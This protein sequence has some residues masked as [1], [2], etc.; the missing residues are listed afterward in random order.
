MT[1]E[2]RESSAAWLPAEAREVARELS[3]LSPAVPGA[4]ALD[5]L[6]GTV[7]AYV[8]LVQRRGD[9]I[10]VQL[11]EVRK[12]CGGCGAFTTKR[13]GRCSAAFCCATCFGPHQQGCKKRN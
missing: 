3:A 8:P 1:P 12:R 7:G 4:V 11:K 6:T 10:D 9:T 13:C 5:E 2:I